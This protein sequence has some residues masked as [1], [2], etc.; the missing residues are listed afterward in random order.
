MDHA[1]FEV[2]NMTNHA[3][4]A[5]D[6]GKCFD[7][8]HYRAV[9]DRRARADDD[10][11]VVPAQDRPGPH[12]RLRANTHVAYH[13]GVGMYERV[14]VDARHSVAEGVDGHQNLLWDNHETN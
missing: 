11:A 13:H 12:G 7:R 2:D 3:V 1:P 6:G 14:G 10:G 5:D 8:V 9:L 4:V